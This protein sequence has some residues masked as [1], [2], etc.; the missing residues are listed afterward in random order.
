VLLGFLLGAG[1]AIA[2][3]LNADFVRRAAPPEAPALQASIPLRPRLEVSRPAVIVAPQ[4]LPPIALAGQPIPTAIL[5]TPAS[6]RPPVKAAGK[7][8]AKVV[9]ASTAP[10]VAEDAAATGMTSHADSRATDLY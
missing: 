6:P 4:S 8:A 10:Q 1:A 5:T 3:L 9:A 7:A 2:V